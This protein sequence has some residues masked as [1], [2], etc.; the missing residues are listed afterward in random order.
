MKS[1]LC[2][3][4]HKPKKN[5]RLTA[6]DL[7]GLS[8]GDTIYIMVDGFSQLKNFRAMVYYVS[9]TSNLRYET[10]EKPLHKDTKKILFIKRTA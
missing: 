9:G 1:G 6:K 5:S 3:K 2:N 7:E 10:S 4:R 8:V